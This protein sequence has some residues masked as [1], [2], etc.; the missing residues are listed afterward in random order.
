MIRFAKLPLATVKRAPEEADAPCQELTEATQTLVKQ[1]PYL[2]N[3]SGYMQFLRSYGGAHLGPVEVSSE[4]TSFVMIYGF[5]D[6]F[7]D[8]MADSVTP[9][10]FYVFCTYRFGQAAEPD[11]VEYAFALDT[12][13]NR[14]WGV[15]RESDAGWRWY[16]PAFVDLLQEI[17]GSWYSRSGLEKGD[18]PA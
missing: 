11:T 10:G 5:G 2:A 4:L 17:V 12:T 18:K 14:R 1:H 9:E 16:C 15:Y 3:D 13:G 8:P 7:D 6:G